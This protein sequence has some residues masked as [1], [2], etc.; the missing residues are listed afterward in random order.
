MINTSAY[1]V[2][3][4]LGESDGVTGAVSPS[5]PMTILD[6]VIN[7]GGSF[8]YASKPNRGLWVQAIRGDLQ[9]TVGNEIRSLAHGQGLAVR[10]MRGADLKLSSSSRDAVQFVLFDGERIGESYVQDGP[11]VM[12]STEQIADIRT[13]YQAGL[14]GGIADDR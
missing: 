1:R 4:A 6:G 12:G 3:V 7:S 2:R 8:S 5:I 14:L 10:S 13:A 9:V 11:F